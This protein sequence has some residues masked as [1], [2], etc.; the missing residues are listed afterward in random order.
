[1]SKALREIKQTLSICDVVVYVLDARAPISSVN[2]SLDKLSQN[3]PV[4][5]VINK[6][7]MADEKR[8]KELLPRFKGENMDYVV[9]NS[10]ASGSS[11]VIRQKI[12][13]LAKTKIDKLKAKGIKAV[14]RAIVVGVPNSGKSTLTNNLCGKAKTQTG[15]KPGVTKQVKWLSIGDNIELC[16]TPGTLYPNLENQDIAKKLLFI[17]SIKDEV[18][19]ENVFLAEDLIELLRKKYPQELNGRYGEFSSLEDIAVKRGFKL[20]KDEYD[21]ERAANA[22]IDDFRKGR[23]GK[24][25]LD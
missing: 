22:V 24:I 19:V 10:T 17:G 11:K 23:I 21:I 5:Y 14:I 6:I 7:D 13:Q 4:L 16:D 8:V 2:P 18:I 25:T 9:L 20:S 15:N 1:M 12:N 3:K